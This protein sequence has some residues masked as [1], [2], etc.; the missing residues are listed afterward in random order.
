M[1]GEAGAQEAAPESRRGA[2]VGAAS[3]GGRRRG[4]CGAD[5][6]G[7]EATEAVRGEDVERAED[8]LER[9]VGAAY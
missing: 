3:G 7:D 8:L 4:E 2:G 1:F 5:E 9:S 6:G